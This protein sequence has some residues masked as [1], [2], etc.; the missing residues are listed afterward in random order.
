M[1][2]RGK[3][4]KAKGNGTDPASMHWEYS[5]FEEGILEV[6]LD[7]IL[8]LDPRCSE[9]NYEA[10]KDPVSIAKILS[11]MGKSALNDGIM[12]GAYLPQ[13]VDGTDFD[14]WASLLD[15]YDDSVRPEH[16]KSSYQ[17][18]AQFCKEYAPTCFV[19]CYHFSAI[20]VTFCR[21]L[22]IPCRP[23]TIYKSG[24]K[25]KRFDEHDMTIDLHLD[26]NG[27]GGNTDVWNYHLI[28]EIYSAGR[29]APGATEH[30]PEEYDGW[31]AVDSSAE[32]GP[33]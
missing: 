15:E 26:L 28:N 31:A 23:V 3:I 25:S 27:L 11:A 9:N 8:P 33:R 6:I 12:Y 18:L 32:I 5:Q 13:D 22:G 29:T 10:M 30:W 14:N 7:V 4:F 17:I 2:E 20:F 24:H 21:A 1:A 19:Q 16:W